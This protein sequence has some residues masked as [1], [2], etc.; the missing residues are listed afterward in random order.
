ML[1]QPRVSACIVLYR[2]GQIAEQAVASV[3]NSDIPIELHL[4]DNSPEDL[5]SRLLV[6]AFPQVHYLPQEKNL[7]YGQGN[8][9]AM[10]YMRCEYHI[11][12]NPDVTFDPH[13]VSRMVAFMDR[14]PDVGIL[15]PRVFFP[16]GQEQFVPRRQPT[17]R[18]MAAR[19]LADRWP[20]AR[21][22]RDAYTL[23]DREITGPTSVQF[24][25]GCFML[26]RKSLFYRLG[27]FD[28][29]FFLYHE[30]SDLSRRVLDSG[31]A[32]VYHPD[33][34][35]THVWTRESM[36]SEEARR[37]HLRSTFRFFMKWGW[38]W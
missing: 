13:L 4:V 30:D 6:A 15:T 14:H 33:F 8:N 2:S 31:H 27:G 24:A 19:A 18:Y 3:L 34:R 38:K 11:I 16:D 1:N 37:Q 26:V 29:R 35:I 36:H 25:T 21:K 28:Q 12:M 22:W 5:Q 32:I 10:K 17:I 20:I 9:A 23:A 7:G